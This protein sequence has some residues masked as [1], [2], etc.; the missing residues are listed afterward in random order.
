MEPKTIDSPVCTLARPEPG[1]RELFMVVPREKRAHVSLHAGVQSWAVESGG[2]LG[3]G[4][5]S[6]P[7]SVVCHCVPHPG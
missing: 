2:R 7:S 5:G 6:W 3:L 1:Q 4:A